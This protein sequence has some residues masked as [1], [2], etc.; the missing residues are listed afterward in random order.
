MFSLWCFMIC[1]PPYPYPASVKVPFRGEKYRNKHCF[2]YYFYKQLKNDTKINDCVGPSFLLPSFLPFFLP[3]FLPSFLPFY[4]ASEP[5]G[6]RFTSSLTPLLATSS[7]NLF[8][9]MPTQNHFFSMP[10]VASFFWYFL[11]FEGLRPTR[12]PS[13]RTEREV[14]GGITSQ[15][16]LSRSGK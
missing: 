8:A 1:C 16:K 9:V 5:P 3:F 10:L 7:G 13:K 6:G 11:W 14:K 15:Q 4:F 2:F 12:R